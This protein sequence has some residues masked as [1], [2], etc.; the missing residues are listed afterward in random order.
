MLGV[1][2]EVPL[3]KARAVDLLTDAEAEKY[4]QDAYD[5]Y[6]GDALG[7]YFGSYNQSSDDDKSETKDSLP[8]EI[9]DVINNNSYIGVASAT[10]NSEGYLDYDYNG[11]RLDYNGDFSSNFRYVLATSKGIKSKKDDLS[12]SVGEHLYILAG[13]AD[14]ATMANGNLPWTLAVLGNADDI[15]NGSYSCVWLTITNEDGSEFYWNM[16]DDGL[17]FMLKNLIDTYDTKM[18]SL[19]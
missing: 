19:T 4:V 13:S 3:I 12:V 5:K 17:N 6:L 1:Q 15:Q 16:K 7:N 18:Q 11:Q 8:V 10:V 14:A 9:Q 2:T